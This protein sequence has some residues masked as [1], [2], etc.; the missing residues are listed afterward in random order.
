MVTHYLQ[1]A[2]WIL[3][4]TNLLFFSRGEIITAT[5]KRNFFHNIN[6]VVSS[7][8]LWQYNFFFNIIYNL[9]QTEDENNTVEKWY[10]RDGERPNRPEMAIPI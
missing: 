9:H 5:T 8:V 2:F 10:W 6:Y 3:S 7:S 4:T 1:E